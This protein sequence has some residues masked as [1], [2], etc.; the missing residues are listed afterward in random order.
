MNGESPRRA[1]SDIPWR[2]ILWILLAVYAAL[3]LILNNEQT[4]VSFVFFTIETRL[5]WLVLMS[6]ALGAGLM[7]LGPRLLRNRRRL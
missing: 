1:P 5:I 2:V 6:M 7:W 4:D 3:F